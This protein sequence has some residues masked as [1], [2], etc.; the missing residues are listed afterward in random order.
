MKAQWHQYVH[1]HQDEFV[2]CHNDL[3]TRHLSYRN[4]PLLDWEYSG[5]GCRY[6]DIASCSAINEFSDAQQS[7][8][9]ERYAEFA[10]KD[11]IE[12]KQGVQKISALVTFTYQ[13]W[14]LSVGLP[15]QRK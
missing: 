4:G 10:N 1:D 13:L 9:C 14:S 12:V 7:T 5:L 6:F 8:L 2:L 11:P 3:H 15:E